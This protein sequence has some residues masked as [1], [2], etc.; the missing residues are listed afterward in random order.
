MIAYDAIIVGEIWFVTSYPVRDKE[1]EN[2]IR[3]RRWVLKNEK[4]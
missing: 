4:N 2:R 1:I 3:A